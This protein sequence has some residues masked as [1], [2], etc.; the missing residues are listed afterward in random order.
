MVANAAAEEEAK[1]EVFSCM[2]RLAPDSTD[3][4]GN[5]DEEMLSGGLQNN[6]PRMAE[7][8]CGQKPAWAFA[9]NAEEPTPAVL[10]LREYHE[11]MDGVKE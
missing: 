4:F 1:V 7:V 6:G 11:I 8:G 3:L 5:Y 9:H 10:A 2:Q